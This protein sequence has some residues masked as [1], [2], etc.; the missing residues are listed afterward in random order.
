M[1]KLGKT[2]G[3]KKGPTFCAVKPFKRENRVFKRKKMGWL[4]GLEPATPGTT[5]QGSN[6]LNYSHHKTLFIKYNT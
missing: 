6:L 1:I 4:T 3:N 5:I 2:G